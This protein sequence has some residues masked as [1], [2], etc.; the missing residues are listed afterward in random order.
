M[1]D[2][3]IAGSE[4]RAVTAEASLWVHLR[5][6]QLGSFKFVRQA[7]LGPHFVDFLCRERKL[8]VEV[9]GGTHGED[10]EIVAD[11]AREAYLMGLGYRVYRASNDDVYTKV[12]GVLEELIAI[13]EGRAGSGRG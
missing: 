10:Q 6:R 9:D 12:E 8:V 13:L 4:F 2:Q 11:A 1:E 7:P 3:S 5:N